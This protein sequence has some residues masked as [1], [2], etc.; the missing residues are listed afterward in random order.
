MAANKEYW[1]ARS[2]GD[3]DSLVRKLGRRLKSSRVGLGLLSFFLSSR[4]ADEHFLRNVLRRYSPS[5]VLDVACGAGKPVLPANVDEV[6]GVDI[7][8]FPQHLA[9]QIGYKRAI[10]YDAPDYEFSLDTKVDLVTCINLNAHIPFDS[11]RRIQAESGA[12]G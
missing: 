11:L 6:Y 3:G 1:D 5:S 9:E 2:V 8:G 10:A 12:A 4:V 7:T